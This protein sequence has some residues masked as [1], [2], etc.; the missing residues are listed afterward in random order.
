QLVLQ[1]GTRTVVSSH[2]VEHTFTMRLLFTVAF[3][4]TVRTPSR[5]WWSIRQTLTRT[6]VGVRT[7]SHTVRV[8]LRS[9][10]VHTVTLTICSVM[11][12]TRFT[13]QRVR[14]TISVT[15][16][17]RVWQRPHSSTQV[18]HTVRQTGTISVTFSRMH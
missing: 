13:T 5:C 1:T 11:I 2:T 15:C 7:I 6:S 12:G 14:S 18:T 16:S 17:R 4:R 10:G 8:P 3:S 9:S